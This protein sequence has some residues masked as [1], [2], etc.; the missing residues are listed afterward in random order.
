M[1]QS[2]V[3]NMMFADS[4]LVWEVTGNNYR[5]FID[6]SIGRKFRFVREVLEG[7]Y[8][9]KEYS[10]GKAAKAAGISY[11]GLKN[12]EEIENYQPNTSTIELL[13]RVYNLPSLL[14]T[15]Q[16]YQLSL[17]GFLIGKKENKAKFLGDYRRVHIFPHILD[18]EYRPVHHKCNDHRSVEGIVGEIDTEG[19]D[20]VF[21]VNGKMSLDR[22]TLQLSLKL[23]QTSSSI[24]LQENDL[25][26]SAIIVPE[27]LE[28]LEELIKREVEF[29]ERKYNQRKADDK[30]KDVGSS[31][32]RYL[33]RLHKSEQNE[34]VSSDL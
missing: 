7:L 9:S 4:R 12:I 26:T 18:P 13:S 29:L 3:Q 14:F 31:L 11:Q 19:E 27:D 33:Q 22:I 2:S 25:V 15:N 10:R 34:N 24:L 1:R 23:F 28:H 30:I 21:D 6:Y 20:V 16:E 5:L 32:E 8:S 17:E